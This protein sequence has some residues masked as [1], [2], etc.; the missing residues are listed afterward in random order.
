MCWTYRRY[1][2]LALS[3]MLLR[4]M[5]TTPL[6]LSVLD[7]TPVYVLN[8]DRSKDRLSTMSSTFSKEGVAFDRFSASDGY[9]LMFL[10]LDKKTS[11]S[12]EMLEKARSNNMAGHY[13]AVDD[14]HENAAFVF[15]DFINSRKL[16]LGE[17]G[18]SYS[19]RAIWLDLI[20]RGLSCAIVFED[21]VVPLG[22][23]R[24]NLNEILLCIPK[25]ADLVMLD[26]KYYENSTDAGHR[27]RVLSIPGNNTVGVVRGRNTLYGTYA[28]IITRQG[29]E[30]LLKLTERINNPIDLVINQ[31][32]WHG[33]VNRFVAK[34]RVVRTIAGT[35]IIRKMGR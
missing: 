23:F 14:K 28:Y 4:Y 7:S 9:S 30:K 3:V 13:K 10:N 6:E 22:N 15:T 21:D 26:Y 11:M 20:K 34:Y 19:H 1:L 35:S 18:C 8:L 12:A 29:A 31:L 25:N 27:G 16:S 32:V 2:F 17:I 33:K 24:Q 5:M